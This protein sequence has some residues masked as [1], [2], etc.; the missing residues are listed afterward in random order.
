MDDRIDEY[1]AWIM[2]KFTHWVNDNNGGWEPFHC[3][4]IRRVTFCDEFF[5]IFCGEKLEY[6]SWMKGQ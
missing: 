1:K 2:H 4:K 5:F 3:E 6:P